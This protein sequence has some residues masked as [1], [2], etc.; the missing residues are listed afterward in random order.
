MSDL[1]GGRVSNKEITKQCGVLQLQLTSRDNVMADRD[2]EIEDILP[3]GVTLNIPHFKGTAAQL[4]AQAVEDTK[5]IASVRIHVE[6]AIG[7]IKT[8]H[9]LDGVFPLSLSHVANQIFRV[10]SYLTYFLPPLVPIDDPESDTSSEK[11]DE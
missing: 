3:D 6:R 11:S 5:S 4:S 2:F 8:Y 1:W 10:V 7:R 9:I